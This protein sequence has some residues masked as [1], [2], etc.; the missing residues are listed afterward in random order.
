MSGVPQGSTI[1]TL[2]LMY[3]NMIDEMTSYVN[4]FIGDVDILRKVRCER[5]SKMLQEDLDSIYKGSQE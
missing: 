4:A 1:Q 2:F 5:Y 3:V